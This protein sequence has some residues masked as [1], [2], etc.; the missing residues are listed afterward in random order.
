MRI[1]LIGAGNVGTQLGH[2]LHGAGHQILQVFSRNSDHAQ[3]LAGNIS[4]I[5]INNLDAVSIDA[6]VVLLAVHDDAIPEVFNQIRWRVPGTMIVHSAGSV[7]LDVFTGHGQYGVIWPVQTLSKTHLLNMREI[8]LAIGGNTYESASIISKLAKSIS[9]Q[10]YHTNDTQRAYLHLAATF[11]NNFSNHMYTLAQEI[12]AVHDIPFEILK[13]L[14][15]ETAEKIERMSPSEAQTG[16]AIRNDKS[17]IL[18]HLLMLKDQKDL[19]EIY[20]L[21][22]QNIRSIR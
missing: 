10:V 20:H 19:Q 17:T 13:P 18:R 5:G 6:E 14:I 21:I 3:H 1:V 4:S 16:A 22:T 7:P 2:A 9:D 12:T 8:P 15:H 11:A